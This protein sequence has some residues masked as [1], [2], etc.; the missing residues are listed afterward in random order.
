MEAE[1]YF[2]PLTE[3]RDPVHDVTKHKNTIYPFENNPCRLIIISLAPI[4][5]LEGT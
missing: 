1:V 5:P 3:H 4:S 2:S